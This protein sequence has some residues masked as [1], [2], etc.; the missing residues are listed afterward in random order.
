MA[1]F[2]LIDD[3]IQ[4]RFLQC[5]AKIQILAGGFANGKT[6]VACVRACELARDYPG[7]NG[8]IAR[9]TY[10]KLNDT[11]RKEF[12][13]WCPPDWIKSFPKSQNASNTC[14]MTNGTTINF[15]YIAQQ[16]KNN[17][18][19]TTSNLLSATYD[20]II[21]DQMEDPEIVHKDFLDLLGRLR[22]MTRYQGDDPR[23]PK[24]GP[25]FFMM[26]VNPT[27]NW[28]Y[29][30]LVKPVHDF[31]K[32]GRISNDLLC[33]TDD[34]G[35]IVIDEEG[36]PVPLIEIFEGSTYE[37]KDNLEADYIRTLE[38]T[39]KGQQ[40]DRYLYGK[41]A[42]Y[43]GLVHPSFD[44]GIHMIPHEQILSYYNKCRHAGTLTILEGYDYGLAVPY[45]YLFGFVDPHGNVLILDGD[46][47]SES[48]VD[49]DLP[50]N[51]SH[52][53]SILSIREEY[54]SEGSIIFCD[55][56]IFRRG[57]GGKKVVGQTVAGMLNEKGIKTQRGNN[58]IANGIVKVNQYLHIQGFH[59]NPITRNDGAPYIMFSDKLEF[60]EDEFNGYYW[61]KDSSGDTEDIPVDKNDHAMNTIKY[62]LSRRPELA[63][64]LE[65]KKPKQVGWYK[66]GERDIQATTRKLA[67]HG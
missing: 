8:L 43:E 24:T 65:F 1:V 61:R 48:S 40:K 49:Q 54:Y 67:R 18:E 63:K 51:P 62:L 36:K 35:A 19:S 27:R 58:H 11:I 28:F 10:P 37:N 45:C 25:R 5:V 38:S 7:S 15:R 23:M 9:S 56:A 42:A 22:G 14:T 44:D 6:S 26:T 4:D 60:V 2:N 55:P 13:K 39:Y 34:D 3:S 29:K 33:V 46:Y 41:W 20:W 52:A 32:Y 31:I 17:Q 57:A 53:S 47:R 59:R 30:K 66:W 12:L 21:V 50:D 16:G 64:I